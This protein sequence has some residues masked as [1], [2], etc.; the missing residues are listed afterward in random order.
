[1]SSARSE[2]MQ[3][4]QLQ[5]PLVLGTIP[6]GL[7]YGALAGQVGLS[8]IVTQGASLIIFAGSAQ[9]IAAQLWATHTPY[10]VIVGTVFI[11]NARHLL[12]SASLAPYLQTLNLFWKSVLSYLLTDEAYAT[13]ITHFQKLPNTHHHWYMLGAG[14]A[15]WVAWQSSTAV[16]VWLGGGALAQWPLDFALPLSF[17]AI[18]VPTLKDRTSIVAAVVAGVLAVALLG[19]PFKLGLLLATLVGIALGYTLE[20]RA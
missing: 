16:G 2:F 18:I 7:L 11:L 17:I 3:G 9:F 19:L 15:M 4:I 10:W 8:A 5:L 20:T 6:F 1:M 12:Y 13:T 14:V